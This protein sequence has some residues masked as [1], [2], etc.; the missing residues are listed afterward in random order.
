MRG[1]FVAPVLALVR[2]L[3]LCGEITVRPWKVA[4]TADSRL[5]ALAAR[6]RVTL[7]PQVTVV[8]LPRVTRTSTS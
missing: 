2:F 6:Q 3:T 7:P 4:K 8:S 5:T 1:R